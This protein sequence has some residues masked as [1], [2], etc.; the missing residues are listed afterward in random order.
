MKTTKAEAYTIDASEWEE[1][2]N[3]ADAQEWHYFDVADEFRVT[4]RLNKRH[5]TVK[6]LGESLTYSGDNVYYHD[7]TAGYPR[8]CCTEYFLD[9][10]APFALDA[11]GEAAGIL[12]EMFRLDDAGD[13][14]IVGK[15]ELPGEFVDEM[16]YHEERDEFY[17]SL[18]YE[19]VEFANDNGLKVDDPASLESNLHA[20][21]ARNTVGGMSYG[22]AN[23]D[24]ETIAGVMHFIKDRYAYD[25]RGYRAA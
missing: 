5:G 4:L 10:F 22:F 6:L 20:F 15:V 11:D 12:A 8:P 16:R 17:D 18:A 25:L 3:G 9:E 19:F 23:V 13:V 14:V 1:W 24:Q 21:I 7:V 2:E